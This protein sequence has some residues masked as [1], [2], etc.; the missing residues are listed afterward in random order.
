MSEPTIKPPETCPRCASQVRASIPDVGIQFECA[1]IAYKSDHIAEALPCV[2]RQRDQQKIEVARLILANTA[3]AERLKAAE[4]VL[5]DP[6]A[7]WTNWLRGGVKLPAGIGDI[8]QLQ[9]RLKRLEEE[10]AEYQTL[11]CNWK[12]YATN[13]ESA[14]QRMKQGGFHAPHIVREWN[15]AMET[16]P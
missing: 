1:S 11:F 7:L 9:E 8:R 12:A 3:L 2:M 16:R 6:Q 13:L 5:T 15:E 4:A 14:G 10:S